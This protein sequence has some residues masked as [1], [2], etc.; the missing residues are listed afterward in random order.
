MAR[1]RVIYQSEA[2]YASK[3][4][5]STGLSDHV[6]L[7][8]VQSANYGFTI[9]RQ[10]VNQYGNLAR[11]D[12]LILEPPTVNFDL[13]YYVTNGFNERAL[14]FSV[15]KPGDTSD[16]QFASG[17][18]SSSSGQNL[19]IVTVPEGK[20]ANLNKDQG[21]TTNTVIGIGNAFLTDYTLDLSVGSLPTA[22][23][24]FEASNIISDTT[25]SG[26]GTISGFTGIESPAVNPVDGVSLLDPVQLPWAS[27][28]SHSGD[29]VASAADKLSA[30]R[31]GD[32]TLDLSNFD[33]EI[34]SKVDGAGGIH[35][36]SA[37]LSLPL[38]RTPI[39]RLGTKFPFARVVDFPVNASL[40]VNAIVNTMEAQNLANMISGCGQETLRDVAVSMKECGGT[41][42]GLYVTLKNCTIDSESF[43]SSIGSNKSVDLTFTTQI[44]GTKDTNKCVFVSGS[45]TTS[46][47][48]D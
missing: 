10:D 16:V 12:S 25:V 47:P 44:G 9:N 39:E 48:W 7:H 40:T 1:N 31:P 36:Q 20:D 11:I 30:L 24:S 2:L 29:Y 15:A 41:T 3:E 21:V 46:L 17:H 33:G 8:R 32:L 26:D 35:I 38:S 13:S 6:Q 18:L 19:F 22:T 27:G 42:T 45:N 34:L 43:S 14:D 23:I 28:N 5:N 4:Y 37:S